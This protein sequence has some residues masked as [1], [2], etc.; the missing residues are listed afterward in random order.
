[1]TQ[2]DFEEFLAKLQQAESQLRAAGQAEYAH[3]N[4]N[5]FG[6]FDRIAKE[7]KLEPEI[8]LWVYLAKHLDGITAY[9]NGHKSQRE[10]VIGRIHDARLYLALLAGMVERRKGE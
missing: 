5:C 4:D 1:M 7:L 6:N 2:S 10:S 9:I 3:E 8:V